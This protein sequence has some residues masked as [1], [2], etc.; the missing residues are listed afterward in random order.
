MG[1]KKLWAG[2]FASNVNADVERFTASISFDRYLC[3][4]DIM[5]SI[6]HCMMLAKQKIISEAES[7]DIIRGLKEIENLIESGR[8]KMKDEHEDIHMLIETM[9]IKKIGASGRKLHTARSRN[10]QIA[11]D[12]RLYLREQIYEIVLLIDKLQKQI[13]ASAKI[14]IDTVMPGFTHLQHAQPVLFSHHLMAYFDMFQRDRQRFENCFERVN[15]MPLGS[16]ALAGTP[17]PVDRKF[18]AR[19][20]GFFSI[21]A[22]SI[23]SV[24]DRDFLIEFC[25]SASITM[26]H[27]SRFCEELVLWSSSE[28]GFIEISDEFCTGSSIMPQK[29][30]PDVAE[31]IRGKTGRVYGNLVSLLTVMKS[32]PLS[33]NRDLQEDKLPL[34]DTVDTT[35]SCLDIFALMLSGLEI[36]KDVMEAA[37]QTGFITATDLAD[38]LVGKKI[39]FRTAHGI[40]G[41]IVAYCIKQDKKLS[42][43]SFSELQK[44]S[45]DIGS[46]VLNC[47]DVSNSVNSRKAEGGTSS[48]SVNNAIKKAAEDLARSRAFLNRS[49]KTVKIKL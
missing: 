17:Y 12:E 19:L 10:D 13:L 35:K 34:F 40:V 45:P 47:L 24:S 11:L 9:L 18:I 38:Y 14:Y 28:F 15:V 5:G 36:K 16:G 29:K 39:P 4:Y 1:A 42:E 49:E 6:A 22:N 25:C 44:F 26:M 21:T 3:K 41:K 7:R 32:L 23:D 27:L 31:I 2:R 43:L 46:D 8:V 20:L 30:N 48:S 37:S 33:Y